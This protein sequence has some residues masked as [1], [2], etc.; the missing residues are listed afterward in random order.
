MAGSQDL[1]T[2]GIANHYW[3]SLLIHCLVLASPIPVASYPGSSAWCR[4]WR[5]ALCDILCEIFGV[6]ADVAREVA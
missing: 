2:R 6:R 4:S 1:E 5:M 3:I